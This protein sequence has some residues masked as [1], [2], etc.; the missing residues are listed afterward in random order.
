MI[1]IEP[2]GVALLS[3]S[4]DTYYKL[5]CIAYLLGICWSGLYR[6][7]DFSVMTSCAESVRLY[8]FT[9]SIVPLK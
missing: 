5:I 1:K 9:S 6:Y 4:D 3:N 8:I 2:A 7:F